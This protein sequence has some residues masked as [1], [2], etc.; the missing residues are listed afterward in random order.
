[1]FFLIMLLSVVFWGTVL[2][3]GVRLVR[4]L[5]AVYRPAPPAPKDR[6]RIVKSPATIARDYA[7]VA[8][9]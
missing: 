7:G 3:L 2:Y 4:A 9:E 6:V 8:S 1:M 5:Y